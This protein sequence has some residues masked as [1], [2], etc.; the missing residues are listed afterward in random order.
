MADP[1]QRFRRLAKAT[2]A[3]TPGSP[4]N[5]LELFSGRLEQLSD[6]LAAY[7]TK[8]QHVALFGE[9]GVGKTSIAN[10]VAEAL[11][12][13]P[14]ASRP[15][16]VRVGCTAADIYQDIWVQIFKKLGIGGDL[17]PEQYIQ[18]DSIRETLEGLDTPTLVVLDEFDRLSDP[19]TSTLFAD[20]IKLLSDEPTM[21]TILLVG[22]ADS[23]DQLVT[24]HKSVGRA[25]RQVQIP[26]MSA[27]ELEGII[28]KGGQHIDLAVSKG[29]RAQ[30]A[31]LSEGLPHYTH[32]LGLYASQRAI[33]DDRDELNDNDIEAAKAV[34]VRKAQR[35]IVTAYN[36][37]TRSAHEDVLFDK[38]LLACA[39][40]VK[41]ELGMFPARD[42]VKPLQLV[43]GN[44]YDIPA[45]A[46]HLKQFSGP[47]RGNILQRHGEPRRY[48]YRFDDPM[49]QPF[50]I[51]NG[52]S[53]GLI[54]TELLEQIKASVPDDH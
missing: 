14:G 49:M 36:K 44:F 32:A 7:Q 52:L 5:N 31:S 47:E 40:A 20:T 24:D 27:R 48:F 22:V 19:Q 8:G 33:E 38:V 43:T 25:L 26:R 54:E 28:E 10:I 1:S 4:I 51:L 41:D 6:I 15:T 11:G 39:L 18:P 42:V 12:A 13:R 37:A 35:T 23:L 3:F 21:A 9:R 46:R 30:I 17:D 16:S 53:T 2:E 45:F 29:H 34:A 50:I